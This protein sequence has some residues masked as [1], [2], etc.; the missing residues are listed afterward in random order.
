MPVQNV[1]YRL[2][3]VKQCLSDRHSHKAPGI[4]L[5]KLA[6]A[7]VV[8]CSLVTISDSLISVLTVD[9]AKRT[10]HIWAR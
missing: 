5:V 8:G 9:N 6:I 7:V 2:I 10:L 1:S 3:M 4:H